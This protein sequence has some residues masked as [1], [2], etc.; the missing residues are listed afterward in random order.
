MANELDELNAVDM[1]EGR[2]AKVITKQIR[3][4]SVAGLNF[5]I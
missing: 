4:K 5:S 2:D 1:P 3:L